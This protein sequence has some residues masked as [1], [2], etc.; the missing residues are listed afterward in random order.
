MCTYTGGVKDPLRH[1]SVC[2]T[3]EAITEMTK[4]LLN[5]ELEDCSK[6][7]LNPFC[8]LNPPPDAESDFWEKQYDHEAAKKARVAKKAA[9]KTAKKNKKKPSASSM[10]ELDDSSESEDDTGASQAVEEEVTIISSDSE[11]LPRQKFRR[12]TRKVSFSHPLAHLYPHFLLKQQQHENRR[13]T[14]TSGG[15]ELSSSLPNTPAPRKRRNEEA[16]RS[17]SGDSSQ[18][19][20]PA[21]KTAP[22]GQ[23]KPS[24]KA[25][26]TKLAENPKIHEPE[27]QVPASNASEKQPEEPAHEAPPEIP[28]L[29]HGHID[30]NPLNTKSSSPLKPSEEH[31]EDV[32]ITGTSF[33]EPGQPTV[34]AKHS[35]KD[36]FVERRK[37]RFD[38]ADYSQLSVSEVFSGYLN[39]VHTSRDLE[40]D[41][42]KQMHQKYENATAQ[43]GRAHV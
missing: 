1:S 20:L 35:A 31:G 36:E 23:A 2:L 39:Q 14:R 4:T 9:K 8:K 11:P 41:M 7:G 34:L 27:Q 42:V 28:D 21:F 25:R 33:R 17:S 26:V 37:V 24:K 38:I 30:I 18:T 5:E 32:M 40:I 43:I 29:S 12:V 6:V 10:F 22:G 13:Q 16:S 15:E 3:N 19:Q